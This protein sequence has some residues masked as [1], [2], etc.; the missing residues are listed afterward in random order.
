MSVCGSVEISVQ[1]TIEK[2][3]SQ[4]D[5]EDTSIDFDPR[6]T[7]ER[8]LTEKGR[9]YQT[10]NLESKR[11]KAYS[12]LGK[13]ISKIGSLIES[14]AG[15]ELLEAERDILDLEKGDFNQACH[16]YEKILESSQERD[17]AY[18]W[19][20]V[21]DRDYTECKMRLTQ[22]LQA[23]GKRLYTVKSVKSVSSVN[24]KSTMPTKLSRSSAHSR[25]MDAGARAAKLEVEMK[26]LEQEAEVRHL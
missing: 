23:V 26:F 22:H 4:V 17:E 14:G 12:K 2:I 20:D 1:E 8:K 11:K 13:H 3:L 21:R 18:R 10:D 6:E 9:H 5:Q 19:F 7:C 24:S 16:A 25:L 15:I